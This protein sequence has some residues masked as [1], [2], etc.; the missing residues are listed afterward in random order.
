MVTEVLPVDSADYTLGMLD[1]DPPW[2]HFVCFPVE[3]SL[4]SLL[5]QRAGMLERDSPLTV[6]LLLAHHPEIV[7]LVIGAL[8]LVV[9]PFEVIL[10]IWVE[11]PCEFRDC[12]SSHGNL[13]H[14]GFK[15]LN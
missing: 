6:E 9:F 1:F 15:S 8:G 10:L 3:S 14:S 7:H 12:K 13:E 11:S 4:G 5:E 2:I